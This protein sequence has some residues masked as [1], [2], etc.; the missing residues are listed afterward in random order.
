MKKTRRWLLI[1]LLALLAYVGFRSLGGSSE[2]ARDEPPAMV[3]NRVLLE[4]MPDKP[5]DYVQGVVVLDQQPFGLFQ[6]AS[7]FDYHLELFEYDQDGAKMKVVFPQ[8]DKKATFSYAIKGCDVPPFDLCLTLTDNPWGGPTK[9]YGF[10]D[11]EQE[12]K[13]LPGARTGMATRAA[14]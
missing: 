6:R 11:A 13:R 8:T 4:K 7:T 5:T 14:R 10:R 2:T 1:P 3:F 12:S 9:Y